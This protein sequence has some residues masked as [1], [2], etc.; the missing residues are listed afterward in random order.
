MRSV[1]GFLFCVFVLA[2]AQQQFFA[3]FEYAT[4]TPVGASPF[5]NYSY[6]AYLCQ[7]KLYDGKTITLSVNLPYS[8]WD[9]DS[10]SVV[11]VSVYA[12]IDGTDLVKNNTGSDGRP[13]PSFSWTYNVSRGD[14]NL[15]VLYSVKGVITTVTFTSSL[16]FSN[17]TVKDE[18]ALAA[19]TSAVPAKRFT[20]INWT[21]FREIIKGDKKYTV[22]TG[23]SSKPEPVLIDFSFC[24]PPN[25]TIYTLVVQT[26]AADVKSAMSL[27][28]CTDKQLPC[29]AAN[30]D[31]DHQDPAGTA[32]ATVLLYTTSTEFS[33]LEAAV[34]GVGE[35]EGINTFFFVVSSQGNGTMF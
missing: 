15:Y 12:N 6:V 17:S 31:R 25:V 13:I 14:S 9:Y 1:V 29:S 10:L 2:L 11:F 35:F 7:Q 26:V 22:A 23:P 21:P 18:A 30:S 19:P 32:V 27:Y 20:N 4:P 3:T 34:Y 33:F 28:I 16:D 8:A 24:P 5:G